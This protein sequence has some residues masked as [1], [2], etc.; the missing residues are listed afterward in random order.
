MSL[1]RVSES[2]PYLKELSKLYSKVREFDDVPLANDYSNLSD[3]PARYVGGDIDTVV[4]EFAR[5]FSLP[6]EASSSLKDSLRAGEI[7]FTLLPQMDMPSLSAAF[8]PEGESENMFSFLY[9]MSRPYFRSIRR[10]LNVDN[11]YWEEGRCPVC[12]SVPTMSVIEK[13]EFRKYRCSFCGTLGH[14]RR[15][16][17]PYCRN[18]KADRID[19]IYSD[20]DD[21]VRVDA[22]ME[23]RSYYKTAEASML[24]GFD[25]E[26]ID[27][28]S[29]PFDIVAQDKG[30]IRRSPNPVGII[31]TR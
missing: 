7:D 19:I 24:S 15:I 17:C 27:L 11:I 22:C 25:M 1:E 28:I 20:K 2:M 8:M 21:R 31:S 23:C 10:R 26:E 12:N 14:Y 3:T 29:L 30:F 4:D 13:N 16:G 18:E 9:I 6:R 5:I